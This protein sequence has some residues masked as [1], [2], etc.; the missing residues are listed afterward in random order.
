MVPGVGILLSIAKLCTKAWNWSQQVIAIKSLASFHPTDSTVNRFLIELARELACSQEKLLIQAGAE[1]VKGLAARHVESLSQKLLVGELPVVCAL[2]D[3]DRF[4]RAIYAGASQS[5]YKETNA[6]LDFGFTSEP[7]LPASRVD[8]KIARRLVCLHRAGRRRR[9]QA[10][11]DEELSRSEV[12]RIYHSE[13]FSYFFDAIIS[14]KAVFGGFVERNPKQGVGLKLSG[15][16]QKHGRHIPYAGWLVSWLA[17]GVHAALTVEQIRVIKLVASFT[18]ADCS[19]DDFTFLLARELALFQDAT[20]A[21][22]QTALPQKPIQELARSQGKQI[23]DAIIGGT[24]SVHC[25]RADLPRFVRVV[26]PGF[27]GSDPAPPTAESKSPQPPRAIG[28]AAAATDHIPLTDSTAHAQ[29]SQQ[30]ANTPQSAFSASSDRMLC[31][32]LMDSKKK[33]CS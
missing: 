27:V 21:L 20:Q 30:P 11:R 19:L 1:A 15:F 10:N 7:Q 33:M 2:E 9:Q 22:P 32:Y 4:L 12:C 25:S 18:A 23:M 24:L 26:C 28:R 29:P 16:I 13:F 31:A 14:A 8:H 17:G 5:S 6:A 3:V